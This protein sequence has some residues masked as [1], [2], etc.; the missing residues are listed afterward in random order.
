METVTTIGLD[1][2]KSVLQVQ[3]IALG[4]DVRL[5]PAQHVKPYVRRGKNDAADAE[6]ICEEAPGEE[7]HEDR[8][9]RISEQDSADGLGLM[10]S[11]ER[12]Q[13]PAA[14]AV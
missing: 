6:A 4:H 1:I 10:T 12:H 7:G 11:G 13:E 14:A 3:L 8:R 5:M 2:A 9:G